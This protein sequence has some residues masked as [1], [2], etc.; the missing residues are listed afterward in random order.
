M[1]FTSLNSGDVFIIDNGLEILQWQGSGAGKE[2]KMRA[3]Q[4][5]LAHVTAWVE[6]LPSHTA[7]DNRRTFADRPALP[8]HR[9]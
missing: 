8:C 3:G 1:A 9:C 4:P 6:L 5:L 7:T 2:E